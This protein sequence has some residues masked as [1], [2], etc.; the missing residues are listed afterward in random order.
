M[1]SV[2]FPFV[3]TEQ[4]YLS[5]SSCIISNLTCHVLDNNLSRKLCQWIILI[6][7]GQVVA[8]MEYSMLTLCITDIILESAYRKQPDFVVYQNLETIKRK[9]CAL[10][11]RFMLTSLISELQQGRWRSQLT[12]SECGGFSQSSDPPLC[13]VQPSK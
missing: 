4:F 7:F 6:F 13:F 3:L 2:S 11:I 12:P 5:V 1:K 10:L 8:S 9:C